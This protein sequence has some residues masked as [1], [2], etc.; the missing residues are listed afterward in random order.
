[1]V[2]SRPFVFVSQ[3]GLGLWSLAQP[4]CEIVSH[5]L[6]LSIVIL[7]AAPPRTPPCTLPVAPPCGIFSRNSS[8]H[9]LRSRRPALSSS[10]PLSS[11]PPLSSPPPLIRHC[12]KLWVSAI[13][14][15]VVPSSSH[16]P[17]FQASGV[18]HREFCIVASFYSCCLS[19][20]GN[21][22]IASSFCSCGLSAPPAAC[23]LLL[24]LVGFIA[25]LTFLLNVV[26][27]WLASIAC[28]L[29]L[30]LPTARAT[31]FLGNQG[32]GFP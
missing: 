1:M 32:S 27:R 25:C 6:A 19:T 11:F 7:H 15:I 23:S 10:P 14:A 30:P 3:P 9:F 24:L 4:G 28:V 31:A 18:R 22:A 13:A 17:S 8:R 29:Y 21:L 20:I 12:S 16:R 5:S 2:T 26:A